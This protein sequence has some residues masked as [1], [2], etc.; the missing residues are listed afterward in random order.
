VDGVG[1]REHRPAASEIDAPFALANP[2]ARDAA[3]TGRRYAQS[4]ASIPAEVQIALGAAAAET[5]AL[6]QTAQQLWQRRMAVAGLGAV[7]V[8]VRHDAGK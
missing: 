6:L 4:L 3:D 7:A 2:A 1:H 5:A 8:E